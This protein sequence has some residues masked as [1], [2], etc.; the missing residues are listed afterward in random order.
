[1]SEF[2]RTMVGGVSMPRLICGSNWFLGYSHTSRAK[3][4]LIKELFDTPA[5]MARVVEVFARRGCNAF[6]SMQSQFVA[7]ALR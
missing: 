3:D 5:K 4:R 6:M 7:E 1:M 2:P